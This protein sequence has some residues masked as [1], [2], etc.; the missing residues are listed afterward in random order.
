MAWLR[1]TRLL[2]AASVAAGISA[3]VYGAQAATSRRPL[4]AG[5]QPLLRAVHLARTVHEHIQRDIRDYTC[6]FVKRERICGKLTGYQYMRAAIRHERTEGDKVV[7][8]FS[9]HLHFLGPARLRDREVVYVAGENLGK[10]IA[11]KGGTPFS[12][13][14]LSLDPLN[15]AAMRDNRYPITEIGIE[16]LLRRLVEM[17]EEEL[18]RRVPALPCRVDFFSDASV[19]GRRCTT[20]QVT[21][22]QRANDIH[23]FQARVYLDDELQVPIRYEAYD[24]A[25]GQT[26]TPRLVEEYTYLDMR[27]NVGLTDA[28]FQRATLGIHRP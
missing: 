27:L 16:N 26:G 21:R 14:T 20:I 28:D 10:L 8:P 13:V 6:L 12:F 4:G 19:N 3:L 17:G 9:V 11:R 2:A 1:T 23:F 24:L 5:P 25:E 22:P 15:A 18:A 7:V